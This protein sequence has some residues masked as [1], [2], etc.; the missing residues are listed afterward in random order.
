MEVFRVF[1]HLLFKK[2]MKYL[3]ESVFCKDPM[4]NYVVTK[5]VSIEDI[6]WRLEVLSASEKNE[7][8]S[9]KTR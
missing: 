2:G 9:S 1:L 8:I 7:Y 3:C 5:T 4:F 6:F